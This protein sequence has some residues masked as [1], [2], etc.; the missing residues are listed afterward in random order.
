MFTPGSRA[1]G[2]K[3]ASGRG[4]WPNHDPIAEP[5]FEVLR[6]LKSDIFGDGPNL[7]L[8][9]GNAPVYRV[10]AFGLTRVESMDWFPGSISDDGLVYWTDVNDGQNGTGN[11][12]PYY[13]G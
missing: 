6:R 13:N 10:D 7:Y 12:A 2:Y 5:G 4:E 9:V 11:I 8:F 3:T 1:C